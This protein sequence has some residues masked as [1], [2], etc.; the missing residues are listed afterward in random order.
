M[1]MWE[2]VYFHFLLVSDNF[3][4]FFHGLL[5]QVGEWKQGGTGTSLPASVSQK[6]SLVLLTHYPW[7][8]HKLV[9]SGGLQWSAGLHSKISLLGILV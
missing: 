4:M 5:A 8:P 7:G 6:A 9:W 2:S 3:P 1:R